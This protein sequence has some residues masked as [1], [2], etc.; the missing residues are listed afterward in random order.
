MLNK[1]NNFDRIIMNTVAI[2][3]ILAEI[4]RKGVGLKIT[5]KISSLVF[6]PVVLCLVCF[7]TLLFSG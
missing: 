6:K 1:I 3:G 2:E 5:N 7:A 4:A